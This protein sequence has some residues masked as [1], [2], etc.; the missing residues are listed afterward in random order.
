MS[1]T[2]IAPVFNEEE[3]VIPFLT[4]I[5]RVTKGLDENI[6]VVL[7]NDGSTDGTVSQ[8]LLA[9]PSFH[10]QVISFARNFGKEAA[11]WAGLQRAHGGAIIVMDA[12]LQHP[13]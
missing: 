8:A 5:E 4:A 12:D 11:I 1:V 10:L 13:P 7:V 6:S 9:R 2:I 3:N